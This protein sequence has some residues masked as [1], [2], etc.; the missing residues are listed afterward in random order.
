MANTDQ[1]VPNGSS[2]WSWTL[3]TS[4]VKRLHFHSFVNE[5]VWYFIVLLPRQS[6]ANL[7]RMAS[8]VA[9]FSSQ[10]MPHASRLV[11][12]LRNALRASLHGQLHSTLVQL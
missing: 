11:G 8:T 12:L 2:G 10:A 6:P 3:R 5:G 1:L 4:L 7:S 9:S